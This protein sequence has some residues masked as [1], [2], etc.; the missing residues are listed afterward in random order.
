[1]NK[2]YVADLRDWGWNKFCILSTRFFTCLYFFNSNY[3]YYIASIINY[4]NR[5]N[6]IFAT[7]IQP[8]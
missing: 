5:I 7:Q 1:M 4:I 3:H 8:I 6:V 2:F